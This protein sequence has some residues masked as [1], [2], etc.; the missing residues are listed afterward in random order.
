[1]QVGVA[2]RRT[3]LLLSAVF[4]LAMVSGCAGNGEGTHD[5]S[6]SPQGSASTTSPAKQ[7]FKYNKVERSFIGQ[8]FDRVAETLINDI[9][10]G[11]ETPGIS[12][13]DGSSWVT[14]KSSTLPKNSPT[15]SYTVVGVCGFGSPQAVLLTVIPNQAVTSEILEQAREAKFLPRTAPEP[16]GEHI[17]T[18]RV[19]R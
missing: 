15:S 10:P 2:M 3:L 9:Y 8:P 13:E 5:S 19:N 4:V 7:E 11:T 16:C 18:S 1:M 6:D 17:P 12:H 14:G